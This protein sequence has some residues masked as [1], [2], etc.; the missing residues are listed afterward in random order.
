VIAAAPGVAEAAKF[1]RK[2]LK[3]PAAHFRQ[4]SRIT[5][6]VKDMVRAATL[7]AANPVLCSYV[8]VVVRPKNQKAFNEACTHL[9]VKRNKMI[10]HTNLD[11]CM[12]FAPTANRRTP[13][14]FLLLFYGCQIPQLC[15]CFMELQ[16]CIDVSLA[17]LEMQDP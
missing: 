10:V 8:I 13:L 16:D 6:T 7:N 2:L 3:L 4:F 11:P 17:V 9:E 12:C 5:V 14:M 15:M 1:H